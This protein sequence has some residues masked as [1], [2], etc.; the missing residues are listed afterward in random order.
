MLGR[1][2]PY[3]G[4]GG[5]TS[6]LNMQLRGRR[7]TGRNK[8]RPFANAQRHRRPRR[9]TRS[10]AK[11]WPN[12]VT[13]GNTGHTVYGPVF[14]IGAH[15]FDL[16]LSLVMGDVPPTLD[17]A[18]TI[19][20]SNGREG[21]LLY[22]FRRFTMKHSKVGLGGFYTIVTGH[23]RST[24]FILRLNVI[25]I[26]LTKSNDLGVGTRTGGWFQT[27]LHRLLMWAPF[28]L[29]RGRT[30]FPNHAFSTSP[31]SIVV[32][33]QGFDLQRT[34]TSRRGTALHRSLGLTRVHRSSRQRTMR[35]RH[36]P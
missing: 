30:S 4:L 34:V 16:A 31:Q 5:V 23:Q 25:V 7:C 13:G 9:N 18:S 14:S 2:L 8:H 19:E 15:R 24:S 12:T 29:H 35:G 26:E 36:H 27:V 1:R 10:V 17:W 22:L 33:T 21:H 32:G 20:G 6:Q 3:L 11:T 28:T